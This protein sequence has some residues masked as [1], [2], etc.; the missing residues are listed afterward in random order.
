MSTALIFWLKW[1]V[2]PF[3]KPAFRARSAGQIGFLIGGHFWPFLAI[4]GHFWPFFGHLLVISR[5]IYG[6]SL[7]FWTKMKNKTIFGNGI[8]G[9]F[10][11][12]NRFFG[13][14]PFSVIFGDFW[15]FFGYLAS[16]VRHSA[17]LRVVSNTI[18]GARSVAGLNWTLGPRPGAQ[19]WGLLVFSGLFAIF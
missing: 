18:L 15:W 3:F 5:V 11:W 4:F 10:G 17:V 8:P 13:Q 19:N 14:W 6:Y 2:R 7:D 16:T 12:S 1:K 9:P